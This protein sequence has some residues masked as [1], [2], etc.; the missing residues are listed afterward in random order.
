MTSNTN[1]LDANVLVLNRLYQA[2]QFISV[3]R[4]FSLLYKGQV[5]AV[6]EDYKTYDFE[7]WC[8]LPPSPGE[9]VVHTP[10]LK[11][12][13]PWV[14]VLMNFDRI[15]KTDIKFSRKNIYLRDRNKCQYCGKRYATEELNLDHVVPVSRNGKSSWQNIVCSCIAC[16]IRKGNRTPEEAGMSLIRPPQKPR[17]HPF[18][19]LSLNAKQRKIWK[20]F[21]DEA[22][23]NIEIS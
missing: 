16:N 5:M 3:R 22:Y 4:A 6:Q 13:I 9:E 10:S 14:I 17:W 11:I 2:I 1:I 18:R 7:N 12:K 21:I 19:K 23:W 20:N 8:D 15:P